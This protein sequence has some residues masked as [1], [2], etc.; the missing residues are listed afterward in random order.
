MGRPEKDFQ[1]E[2]PSN[3]QVPALD[4]LLEYIE[5]EERGGNR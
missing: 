4:D 3:D 2:A 1:E 5:Q